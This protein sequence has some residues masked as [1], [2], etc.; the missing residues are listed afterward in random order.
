MRR[1]FSKA[2]SL[3]LAALNSNNRDLNA[4]FPIDE[5][6][7]LRT[8]LDGKDNYPSRPTQNLLVYDNNLDF[9]TV[10]REEID[11]INKFFVGKLAELR[12]TLDQITSK[13]R[14]VYYSHHTS[15]ETDLGRLQ[16]IY[17]QLA[18]L[19]SYCDLNRTGFY[20]IIKKHDKIL[21]DKV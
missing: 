15:A 9:F 12:I 21:E 4:V 5:T 20:K 6:T 8:S 3:Q 14:N 7:P 18:A 2:S 10:I 16:D 17:V 13:R 1:E 19:R 11:K